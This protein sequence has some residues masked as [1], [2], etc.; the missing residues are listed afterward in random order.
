MIK[1]VL[2]TNEQGRFPFILFLLHPGSEVLQGQAYPSVIG[3]VGMRGVSNPAMVKRSF[4]WLKFNAHCLIVVYLHFQFLS[5]MKD[6]IFSLGVVM[7]IFS[8]TE[9]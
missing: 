8:I 2:A 6:D 5:P 9:I 7:Q 3:S 1:A 4:S